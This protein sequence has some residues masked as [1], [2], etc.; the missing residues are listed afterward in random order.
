M[1]HVYKLSKS[2]K[3]AVLEQA[4]LLGLKTKCCGPR[5]RKGPVGP[6]PLIGPYQS[7]HVRANTPHFTSLPIPKC[8]SATLYCLVFLKRGST[9]ASLSD[10]VLLPPYSLLIHSEVSFIMGLFYFLTPSSS[11]FLPSL[12]PN[13]WIRGS[14]ISIYWP[15]SCGCGLAIDNMFNMNKVL[16]STLST[17][18]KYIPNWSDFSSSSPQTRSILVLAFHSHTS[19]NMWNTN[20]RVHHQ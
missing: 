19:S 10:S 2:I 18:K 17:T 3:S 1:T 16:S 6:C 4:V 9:W 14:Y 7:I 8:A 5:D 12:W 20:M 11:P 15:E 13:S